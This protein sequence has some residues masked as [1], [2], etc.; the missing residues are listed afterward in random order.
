MS[1]PRDSDLDARITKA[2]STLKES[3]RVKAY[4]D[5][6]KYLADR[7]YSISGLPAPY[8]YAIA[9]PRVRNYQVALGYGL[10]T[11]SLSKL[12]LKPA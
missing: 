1:R 12:W 10:V 4:I 8:V 11:E 2:R 3:D 9:G 7:M 6:Q 5:L